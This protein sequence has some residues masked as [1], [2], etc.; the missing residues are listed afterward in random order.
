[1]NKKLLVI[2]III[3]FVISLP[4]ALVSNSQVSQPHCQMPP[5]PTEE[6]IKTLV[7][8]GCLVDGFVIDDEIPTETIHQTMFNYNN[9][10]LESI[11]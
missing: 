6:Q 5:N 8:E 9:L 11:L 2:P 4:F 7:D 3:L 1:M 10:D